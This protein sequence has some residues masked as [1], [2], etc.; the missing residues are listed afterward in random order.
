MD[1]IDDSLGT[2]AGGMHHGFAS[3]IQFLC[4]GR[5][6]AHVKSRQD[7]PPPFPGQ[8]HVRIFFLQTAGQALLPHRDHPFGPPGQQVSLG[9][10][11]TEHIDDHGNSPCLPGTFNHM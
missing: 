8:N 11:G 1:G 3:H 10:K 6:I 4:L 5:R 2:G 9:G 7:L